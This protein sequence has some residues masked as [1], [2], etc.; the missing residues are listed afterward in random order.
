MLLV[1]LPC[2]AAG[3]DAQVP[4][5]AQIY[6]W[7]PLEDRKQPDEPLEIG[8]VVPVVLKGGEEA[9]LC[10][11]DF[12]DRPR[13]DRYGTLLVRLHLKEARH[14]H[15]PQGV[16]EVI[17]LD[18]DGI[19]E[20]LMSWSFMAQG[21]LYANRTI[22]YFDGWEYVVLHEQSF[23]NDLGW[24][25]KKYYGRDCESKEV[26]WSFTDLNG[27]GTKDLVEI[28]IFEDGDEPD[29]LKSR[30]EVRAYLFKD[31]KFVPITPDMDRNYFPR[32][33]E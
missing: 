20:V 9:F 19:S 21:L 12:P 27:D 1:V 6:E 3:G 10:A 26:H 7:W 17:D 29:K 13:G 16:N 30:I 28:L 11:V 32:L 5:K 25:G 14:V 23:G 8:S 4:S 24:C 33:H 31:K 15:V 2:L 18:A 22:G